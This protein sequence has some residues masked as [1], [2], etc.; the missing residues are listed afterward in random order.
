M[1]GKYYTESQKKAIKKYFEKLK[2]EGRTRSHGSKE[3]N[4]QT[5]YVI[6][7]YNWLPKIFNSEY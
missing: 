3:K 1:A 4:N 6:R 7:A 5:M 2:A